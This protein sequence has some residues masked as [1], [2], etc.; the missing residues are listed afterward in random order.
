MRGDKRHILR[1]Y[2]MHL[3][4]M[5]EDLIALEFPLLRGIRVIISNGN[6]NITYLGDPYPKE[7]ITNRI[8]ELIK[9]FSNPVI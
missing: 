7:Q 3:E 2:N 4:I 8:N 1:T 6:I 5:W 9:E